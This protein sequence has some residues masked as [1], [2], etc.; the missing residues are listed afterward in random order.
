MAAAM[1]KKFQDKFPKLADGVA[2]SPR[3][4]RKL[5]VQAGKCKAVLSANKGAPFNVES[6]FQDTDF[7]TSIKREEFEKMCEDMF[8]KITEP[9]AKAL[10]AANTTMEEIKHVEVV[11]GGWRVPKVQQILTDFVASGGNKL[12]LGQHLNGD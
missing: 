1:L 3:A 11:G 9:I 2:K 6:L 4:L 10:A 8:S 12:T 7:F 5:M